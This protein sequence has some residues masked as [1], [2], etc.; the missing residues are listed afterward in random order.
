MGYYLNQFIQP[1]PIVPK[2]T[3]PQ[4]L[5]LYSYVRNNPIKYT[6]PSGL[7]PYEP[8]DPTRVTMNDRDL[9]WWLYKELTTNV[10]SYYVNALEL[11]FLEQYK[12]SR[13]L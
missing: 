1:D 11:Y 4:S 10:N 3:E 2:Y 12:K 9:T 7:T 13:M 6:D 5:N 8:P